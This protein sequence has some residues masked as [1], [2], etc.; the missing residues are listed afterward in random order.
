ML[1]A[2]RK[3]LLPKPPHQRECKEHTYAQGTWKVHMYVSIF[4]SATLA[5]ILVGTRS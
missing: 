4:F 5:A 2:S 1:P 3:A